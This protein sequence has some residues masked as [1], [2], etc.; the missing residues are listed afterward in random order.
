MC[1]AY[2]T[3]SNPF[4]GD[5]QEMLEIF[6]MEDRG[7]RLPASLIQVVAQSGKRKLVDATWW[8]MLKPDGKAHYQYSTFNSRSD[9]LFT[10]PLTKSLFKSSRCIIPATGFIEGQN[11]KYHLLERPHSALAMGGI[12][13]TYRINGQQVMSASIITC[14][15]GN[16]KLDDIH[17]KSVPL[18]IDHNNQ[19][20]INM[21]L[22]PEVTDGHAF[23]DLLSN[24]LSVDLMAT[25]I[26][27]ARD[28]TPI[29]TPKEISADV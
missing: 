12:C 4:V 25:P 27:R 20:L 2:T 17:K 8:L 5:L 22:S 11:K 6:A 29:D 24:S 7:I 19:D 3:I 26:A 21:W 16:P 1:G 18:I 15:G 23:D 14:P 28:L 9:K 10:S 13:K